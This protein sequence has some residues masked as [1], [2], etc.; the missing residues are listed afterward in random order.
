M[1]DHPATPLVGYAPLTDDE[2]TARAT[3]F[4]EEMARRRT[5]REFSDRPVPRSVVEQALLTAGSAPSGAN[6]QPWFFSVIESADARTRIRE[7]AEA[8]EK[9][10]YE[11]KAPQE[12]L[13]A[14]A[15]LGTDPDKGF[16]E[17]APVLIAI[18]SQKR[19]GPRPGDAK[20][21]YYVTES[22]GIATGLLIAA[23]HK[24]GL[25]TLTHTPAPMS[26]LSEIC[27]R[28]AEEKP[29]LLL[30]AGHPAADATVPLAALD[31]KPLDAI[32]AWI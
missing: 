16:L 7:A 2:A 19:G 8:E 13:Q 14:L 23:L 20:K 11:T 29:F 15:P 5:V 3:G 17:V 30:V 22:V 12:W 1:K 24:A 25:A 28:P 27:G 4:R 10:F 18:F 21:N 26:F 31:K 6:H 32:A 9:A